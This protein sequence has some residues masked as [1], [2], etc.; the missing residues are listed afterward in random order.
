MNDVT[1]VNTEVTQRAKNPVS[2]EGYNVNTTAGRIQ[3]LKD[4]FS[5][6]AILSNFERFGGE[7]AARHYVASVL[8]EIRKSTGDDKRDLS[9]ATPESIVNACIDAASMGLYV[10][11]RK[12]AHLVKR[13]SKGSGQDEVTLQIGYQGYLARL[14]QQLKGFVAVVE[15][16]YTGDEFSTEQN[17]A[18]GSFK[19]I[20]ANPFDIRSDNDVIG[21]YAFLQWES[22]PGHLASQ[23]TTITKAE[24]AK[25]RAVATT[26][27]VW[28]QWF[29]EMAK[30]SVIR[31]ASKYNFAALTHDLDER[32]NDNFD[33]AKPA[34]PSE[35]TKALEAKLAEGLKHVRSDA[36]V[37]GI[38]HELP[39]MKEVAEPVEE[40]PL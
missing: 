38:E 30:K 36:P 1:P 33:I 37:P 8:N 22:T 26:D 27:Y 29:G 21:A 4:Y 24:I 12:H 40:M 2:G 13:Y 16:V 9:K 32:D 14:D 20:R 5:I 18:Q 6:P 25:M 7:D 3:R 10:D 23:V 31:R 19:H 15:L 35:E 28:K 17:A 34:G 39:T 11:G